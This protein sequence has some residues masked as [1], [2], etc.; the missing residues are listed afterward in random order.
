MAARG[1]RRLGAGGA[2]G[3][4]RAHHVA[5]DLGALEELGERADVVLDLP[6]LVVGG[7]DPR[8]PLH[9]LADEVRVATGGDE[10]DV[11][12]AEVLADE[13]ARVPACAIDD[14]RLGA[15]H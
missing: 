14:D 1:Q 5:D 13:P 10:G 4:E 6:D 8:H 2:V 12:L 9:H 11:V 3:D 7:L 15:A